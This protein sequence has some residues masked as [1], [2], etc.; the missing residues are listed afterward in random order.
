MAE[1]F[2]NEVPE[3][4]PF[5]GLGSTEP[6]AYK[7]Y[8]PDRLVLGKRMEDHLRIAVCLWHSFNWPGSDVFGSG[9]FDRPWLES[10]RDPMEAARTKS[11]CAGFGA[12]AFSATT[13]NSARAPIRSRSM[14]AKTA[15]PGLK[16]VTLPP[17]SAT[18]PA[19]SLPSVAGN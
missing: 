13:A 5:G 6:L 9:T 1:A 16:R 14:L 2:F 3:R 11:R 17:T 8:D 10:G 19:K 4:I 7:V 18:T 15:S 12:A